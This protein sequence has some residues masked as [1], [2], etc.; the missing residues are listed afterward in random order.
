M[1]VEGHISALITVTN[2]NAYIVVLILVDDNKAHIHAMNPIADI[3]ARIV[4]LLPDAHIEASQMFTL[5]LVA[6]TRVCTWST[7]VGES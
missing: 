7:I 2:I 5:T 3:D 6:G 1:Y 4:V